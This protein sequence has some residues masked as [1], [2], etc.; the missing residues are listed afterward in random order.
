MISTIVWSSAHYPHQYCCIWMTK[1]QKMCLGGLAAA[2]GA[3][4]E[5]ELQVDDG[6]VRKVLVTS[7]YHSTLKYGSCM[8]C[9]N[10]RRVG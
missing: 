6:R 8:C 3:M 4:Q 9:S 10:D 2:P 7:G 1:Q 5:E